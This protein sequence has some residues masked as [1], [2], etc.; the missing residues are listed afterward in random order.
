MEIWIVIGIF[1]FLVFI[2]GLVMLFLPITKKIGAIILIVGMLAIV[3]SIIGVVVSLKHYQDVQNQ[4][5]EYGSK[6]TGSAENTETKQTHKNYSVDWKNTD[7]AI[8]KEIKKITI[9]KGKTFSTL[10]N[11]DMPG[12]VTVYLTIT[13]K[14]GE[15]IDTYPTQGELTTDAE[16][17]NGADALLSDFDKTK[18]KPNE[19]TTGKLVFPIAKL[20]Q[21][22]D[23]SHIQLNWL[24]YIGKATDPK[25]TETEEIKLPAK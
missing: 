5:F 7:D 17:V 12:S 2:A 11:K 15:T 19:K 4:V 1:A 13:N 14:T 20:K 9:T 8:N 10:E 6:T 16:T 25:R 3:S 23:V 24:N 22:G 21:V 18:L